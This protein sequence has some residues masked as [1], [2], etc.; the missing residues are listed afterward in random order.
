M[1]YNRFSTILQHLRTWD[2]PEEGDDWYPVR[3]LINEYNVN[4]LT[5]FKPGTN[6][7]VDELMVAWR[8]QGGR[9]GHHSDIGLPHVSKII[10]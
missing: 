2:A 9:D 1:S 8:G 4:M 7:C 5:A 10:R 6:I 3:Q